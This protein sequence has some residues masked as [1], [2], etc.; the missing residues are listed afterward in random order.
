METI[1]RASRSVSIID[2]SDLNLNKSY[3]FQNFDLEI[4]YLIRKILHL[5]RLQIVH[6]KFHKASKIQCCI[7]F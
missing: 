4:I 7:L 6:Q 5:K 1:Y 2:F 3:L